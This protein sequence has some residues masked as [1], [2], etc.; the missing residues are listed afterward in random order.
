MSAS[1]HFQQHTHTQRQRNA[2]MPEKFPVVKCKLPPELFTK[3][4]SDHGVS[5]APTSTACGHWI[6][7]RKWKDTQGWEVSRYSLGRAW[8][9][10]ISWL[11]LGLDR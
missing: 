4:P 6:A 11:G 5:T 1:F 8:I 3:F 10:A 2:L 9:E 7:H